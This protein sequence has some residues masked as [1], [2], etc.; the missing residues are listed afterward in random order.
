[1]KPAP[2][3]GGA[4]DHVDHFRALRMALIENDN[5]C[6]SRPL[7]PLIEQSIETMIQL[8]RARATDARDLQR[9]QILYAEFA[10]WLHQDGHN[11]GRAQHWTDRAL[12]WSHQLGDDYG[13]A[14]TLIRKAQCAVDM[15]D[16]TEA[17]ELAEAA[18]RAAPPGTRF[19]ACAATFAGCGAAL[20]GDR[21]TS[22]RAFDRARTLAD[23]E[24]ADPA[25]GLF[26]DGSYIDVHQAQGRAVLGDYGAAIRDYAA[27][28]ARMRPGFTRDQAVYISRAAVAHARAGEIEPAAQM[29]LNAM[30]VGVSTGSERIL[31]NVRHVD[32]LLR[33]I[34]TA[35][36][37]VAEFRDAA[38]RWAVTA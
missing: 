18:E 10:A 28:I 31:Q 27:A 35:A 20:M 6:G 13:I 15:G 14:A 26:L 12:T 16:G 22:D 36:P 7:V 30:R 19:A 5:L 37:E 1:M 17:V 3:L 8:R 24:N 9:I 11:W 25:W 38:D 33:G 21:A 2:V 34:D 29:G 23:D 32:Q 4:V